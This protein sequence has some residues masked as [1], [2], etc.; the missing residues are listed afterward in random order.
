MQKYIKPAR[1]LETML[2]QNY[3]KVTEFESQG[4]SVEPLAKQKK[5]KALFPLNRSCTC[6]STTPF[7]DNQEEESEQENQENGLLN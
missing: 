3:H 2:V 4:S 1:K 5:S 7:E 6:F